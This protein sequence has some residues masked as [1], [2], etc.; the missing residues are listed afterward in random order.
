MTSRFA[1]IPWMVIEK[2]D[3]QDVGLYCALAIHA[4]RWGW[5]WPSQHTLA[6]ICKMSQPWVAKRLKVL[7]ERMVI[8][9][10]ATPTGTKYRLPVSSKMY[11]EGYHETPGG[12]HQT[13][14]SGNTNKIL[15]NTKD[16][17][18]PYSPPRGTS[19]NRVKEGWG[20][21]SEDFEEL[22]KVYP[23]KV[24]KGAARK[25]FAKT[26]RAVDFETF[27]AGLERA[28]RGWEKAKTEAQF[29]PQLSTWLNQERWNDEQV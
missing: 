19:V 8:E 6:E 21:E 2:L 25:S 11:P 18:T 17:N 24:G 14:H 23:K 10:M 16:N 3:A 15:N 12:Y 5:C 20:K 1:V 26:I 28:L 13:Y 22:W 4:D 7:E 27:F 9:R 29:I